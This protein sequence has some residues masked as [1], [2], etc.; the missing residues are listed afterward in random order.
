MKAYV[1][2]LI[3]GFTTLTYSQ[4]K[5]TGPMNMENL[6]AVVI[7]SGDDFSVYLPDRNADPKVRAL[8]DSF[9]AYD[10]GVNYEGYDTYLVYMEIKGG[11]LSATYN[12]NGKL[13]SVV[14]NYKT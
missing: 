3:L 2:V 5:N 4:E 12:E 14:E 13:I 10:L 6:P 8:Q 7:K 11:S 9:I 1:N